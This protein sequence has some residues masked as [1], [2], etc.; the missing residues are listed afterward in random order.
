MNDLVIKNA[1]IVDG[2]GKPAYRGDV[3]VTGAKISHIGHSLSAHRVIDASGLI[4]APG[5]VDIHS[6]SDYTVLVDNRAENKI[7][8]GVTCEVTGNCG[9]SASPMAGTLL[10]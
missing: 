2:T 6:H 8:Q 1:L 9:Y 10:E 7:L 4:I 5:F 3:A